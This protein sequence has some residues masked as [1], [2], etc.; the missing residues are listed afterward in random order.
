[1]I[2]VLEFM[3]SIGFV[4]ICCAIINGVLTPFIVWKQLK[5]E[6]LSIK[7]YL[8]LFII[9]II[10][11]VSIIAFSEKKAHIDYYDDTPVVEVDNRTP[12]EKFI[13]Y[14]EDNCDAVYYNDKCTYQF[15]FDNIYGGKNTI[16]YTIDF[17]NKKFIT[18]SY[19]AGDSYEEYNWVNDTAY[20][21]QVST[22]GWTTT[23]EVQIKSFDDT[24]GQYTYTWNS[25]LRGADDVAKSLA[26]SVASLR[27]D[28]R[29]MCSRAGISFYD[30]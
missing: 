24:T 29:D 8:P 2:N 16:Y 15:S 5:N 9:T 28:F 13:D 20:G 1:M 22:V 25:S 30:L 18:Q 3:F 19:F 12:K 23:T 10:G 27:S 11:L 6:K 4:Y 17:T 21:K 26:E 7:N 14:L